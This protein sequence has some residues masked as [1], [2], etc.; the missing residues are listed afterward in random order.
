MRRRLVA[1]L[2]LKEKLALLLR[3]FNEW[4][5]DRIAHRFH[6]NARRIETALAGQQ[7]GGEL[8]EPFKVAMR[9]NQLLV[10]LRD[11]PGRRSFIDQTS[12]KSLGSIKNVTT[13]DFVGDAIFQGLG[14]RYRIARHD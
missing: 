10:D 5:R 12:G 11:A 14:S 9:G 8:V 2:Q 1:I 4:K 7:T 3:A 6:A 13:G